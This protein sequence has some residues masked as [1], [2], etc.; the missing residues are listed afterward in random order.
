MVIAQ[1]KEFV[2]SQ[3]EPVFVM[4]DLM[5]QIVQLNVRK[6]QRLHIFEQFQL[7]KLPL[8]PF[9]FDFQVMA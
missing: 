1:V 4:M 8:L 6:L 9:I 2:F 7:A 5:V 3:I